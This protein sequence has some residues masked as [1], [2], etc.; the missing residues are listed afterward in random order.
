MLSYIIRRLL[1]L[2]LILLGVTFL[3]FC[4][5][6][7][8]SPMERLA[9]YINDPSVLKSPQSAQRLIDKYHLDDP[10][11]VGYI[12]WVKSLLKLD[13]GWSP[14]AN[15][16]VWEAIMQRLPA[17]MELVLYSIIP[18]ILVSLFG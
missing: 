8:L 2:P 16:P 10:F 13:F 9:T 12:H 5:F 7:L 14:T 15:Q 4:L 17:T 18:V 3:I 6:S 11:P 1:I